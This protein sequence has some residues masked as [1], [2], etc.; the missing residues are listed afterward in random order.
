MRFVRIYTAVGLLIKHQILWHTIK[1]VSVDPR[2]SHVFVQQVE[3][4][5]Q[6]Q[7]NLIIINLWLKYNELSACKLSV[8]KCQ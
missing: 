3:A 8:F 1:I 7:S 2:K 4:Q 5:I 6:S